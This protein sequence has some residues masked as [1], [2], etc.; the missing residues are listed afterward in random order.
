MA[1]LTLMDCSELVRM[2]DIAVKHPQMGGLAIAGRAVV[3]QQKI[4]AIAR[5]LA[6]NQLAATKASSP[7]PSNVIVAAGAWAKESPGVPVTD[8][9]LNVK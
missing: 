3:L 5:Q 4:D 2:L 1:E 9:H 7:P 8:N 6:E